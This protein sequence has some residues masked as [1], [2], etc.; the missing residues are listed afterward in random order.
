M[1]Y[2]PIPELDREHIQE[3]LKSGAEGD[4]ISAV[5]SA[6]L[7][8]NDWAWVQNICL[9]Q[10]DHPSRWV[11][12]A[13]ITGLGHVVRLHGKLD[14]DVVAAKLAAYRESDELSGSIQDLF[15]DINIFH[16]FQD[17]AN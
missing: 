4:V 10:L 15:G 7:H 17:R 13:C 8:D 12:Q 16:R 11:K 9:S 2:Q 14:L 3:Q 6:A 1:K 5:L